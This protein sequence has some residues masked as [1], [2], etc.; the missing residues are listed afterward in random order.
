MSE[1]SDRIDQVLA[2]FCDL[3]SREAFGAVESVF[4]LVQQHPAVSQA[5]LTRFFGLITLVLLRHARGGTVRFSGC[6][7]GR[8]C[9]THLQFGDVY[10]AAL[11][12]TMDFLARNFNKHLKEYTPCQYRMAM[13]RWFAK[14]YSIL[15]GVRAGSERLD[16]LP[17]FADSL[18]EPGAEPPGP[19]AGAAEREPDHD[20]AMRAI[21]DGDTDALVFHDWY[22][23]NLSRNELC[24]LH[25]LP[26][27]QVDQ[28]L[29]RYSTI[30]EQGRLA[31]LVQ[32][33]VSLGDDGDIYLLA[34]KGLSAEQIADKVGKTRWVVHKHLQATRRRFAK[35]GEM[36]EPGRK[37]ATWLFGARPALAEDEDV[38]RILHEYGPELGLVEAA[39]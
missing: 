33:L 39:T 28:A 3:S 15:V 10:E 18:V 37:F 13:L 29:L 30:Y 5:D 9:E 16:L 24:R 1:L 34:G 26:R 6:R 23:G 27:E 32:S 12:R 8:P 2:G 38:R 36:G 19:E 17:D 14:Q 4:A 22:V 21:A 20:A 11:D 31:E 7:S 25:D 35:L